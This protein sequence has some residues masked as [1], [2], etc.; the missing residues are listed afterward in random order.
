MRSS[1][2]PSLPK[3]GPL[4]VTGADDGANRRRFVGGVFSEL[5][6]SDEL[7]SSGMMKVRFMVVVVCFV[8]S[9]VTGSGTSFVAVF[10]AST[11][12][13]LRLDKLRLVAG[14]STDGS[15]SEFRRVLLRSP[16]VARGVDLTFD[17]GLI[18]P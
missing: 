13:A 3:L 18:V 4:L 7:I 1:L 6:V 11:I 14:G 17:T 8:G 5:S 15:G 10:D 9:L 16:D 2:A 12:V